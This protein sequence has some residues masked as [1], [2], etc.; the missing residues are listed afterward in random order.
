MWGHFSGHNTGE[1]IMMHKPPPL[2]MLTQR[3]DVKESTIDGWRWQGNHAIC[4]SPGSVGLVCHHTLTSRLRSSCLIPF[5]ILSVRTLLSL[6]VNDFHFTHLGQSLTTDPGAPAQ[7]LK[8]SEHWR[9]WWKLPKDRERLR[10]ANI[11]IT[12]SVPKLCNLN[13]DQS[14][15]ARAWLRI[16]GV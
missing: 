3:P 9:D 15:S 13:F 14:L 10:R 11:Q 12:M 5:G 8:T 1:C 6:Q 4:T 2:H 7:M 16:S